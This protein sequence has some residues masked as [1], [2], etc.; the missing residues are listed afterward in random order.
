VLA[1]ILIWNLYDSTTSL[2]VLRDYLPELPEDAYWVSND[3]QE[4]LGLIVFGDDLPDLGPIPQLIG[5][6]PVIG[7]EFDVE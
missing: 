6:E 3:S 7:E 4:R 2:A 1:R 5:V